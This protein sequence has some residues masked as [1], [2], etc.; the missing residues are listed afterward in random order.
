MGEASD[1]VC[2][3]ESAIERYGHPL[4]RSW[5][6]EVS[7]DTFL[8]WQMVKGKRAGEVIIV[9]RRHDG[10]YVVHTKAFYPQGVYRLLSGGIKPGEDLITAVQRETWEE[11]G[12]EVHIARFLGILQHE[13]AWQDSSLPFI[14]Y[15]FEVVEENGT[16]HVNDP[17]E[18]ITGY[19]EVVLADLISLAEQLEALPR[20]WHDWGRFRAMPH[21]FVV[22][23]LTE[24]H[25]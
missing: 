10:R 8:Y 25:A 14:S 16:L 5:H 18:A 6:Y 24:K 12:L 23:V 3:I 11:T 4:E 7:K 17:H 22:E 20:D 9:L 1:G 13:F 21:R 2:G 19:R 15:V